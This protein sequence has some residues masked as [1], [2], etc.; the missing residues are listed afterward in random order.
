MNK[1]VNTDL[2]VTYLLFCNW[3]LYIHPKENLSYDS[4]EEEEEEKQ[5]KP[6]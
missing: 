4:K 5:A 3:P 1:W 2:T 6:V